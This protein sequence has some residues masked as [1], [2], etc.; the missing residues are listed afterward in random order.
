MAFP[1]DVPPKRPRAITRIFAA[2]K[3]FGA[4]YICRHRNIL[5]L[6]LTIAVV[7]D[8]PRIIVRAFATPPF[9]LFTLN[10]FTRTM[11]LLKTVFADIAILAVTYL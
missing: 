8:I 3:I 11:F 4:I 6:V 2:F 1:F 10:I 5:H 9:L 7:F